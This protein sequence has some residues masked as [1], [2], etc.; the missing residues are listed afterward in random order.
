M[1]GRASEATTGSHNLRVHDSWLMHDISAK[2]KKIVP[3][4]STL[5]RLPTSEFPSTAAL[6]IAQIARAHG[7]T[8]PQL[9]QLRKGSFLEGAKRGSWKP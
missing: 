7:Q 6:P 9:R 8:S 2:P 1:A 5:P 3:Q 4:P